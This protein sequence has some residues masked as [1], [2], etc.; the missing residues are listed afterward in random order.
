MPAACDIRAMAWRR[1][2]EGG[3]LPALAGFAL[4]YLLGVIVDMAVQ[5]LGLWQGW[6]T[7]VPVL[8]LFDR[9][10]LVPEPEL[11]EFLA[12]LTVQQMSPGY[13]AATIVANAL[14]QGVLAFG[15]AVIA[16]AVIRGGATA[17]QVL[18]G[19]RW[20][21]R[22]AALGFLRTLLVALWSLLLVIP[23]VCAAYSYRMAFFL[24]ADHPDWSPWK[25]VTESKRI[26][27]GHRW[28]LACLDASFIGWF[29]LVGVTFGFAALFVIPYFVTASAAFYED[30][31]DR[32]GR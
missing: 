16:I 2:K 13:Q 32:T 14:W 21:V 11:E 26:M 10:G 9:M 8:D 29:L 12:T 31:L 15:S 24:L 19:F 4:V 18:S 23:G 27:R 30:L 17:F 22:T 5:R 28:R 6:I 7:N 20:P 1:L 25:A 3:L